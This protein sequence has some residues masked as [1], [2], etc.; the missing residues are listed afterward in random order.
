MS[1]AEISCH[2][3]GKFSGSKILRALNKCYFTKH[4]KMNKKPALTINYKKIQRGTVVNELEITWI[5]KMIYFEMGNVL[6]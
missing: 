3:E 5:G 1:A 6:N 4:V 2:F